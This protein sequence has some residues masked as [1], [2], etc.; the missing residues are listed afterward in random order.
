MSKD[1]VLCVSV[2]SYT[3]N[4]LNSLTDIIDD[5][6]ILHLENGKDLF[7]TITGSYTRTCFGTAFEDLVNVH[8]PIRNVPLG[9][10][11]KS[12]DPRQ[13]IPKELW[14]L[15]DYLYQHGL[16]TTGFNIIFVFLRYYCFSKDK[17]KTIC[18]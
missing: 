16:S 13:H 8:G 11:P 6:L 15:V 14:I 9:I 5:I 2:D 7:I 10:I 3:V 4:T 1:V 12:S 17:T 18:M